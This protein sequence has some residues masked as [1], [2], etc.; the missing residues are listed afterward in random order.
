MAKPVVA[1]LTMCSKKFT[2]QVGFW[3]PGGREPGGELCKKK[4]IIFYGFKSTHSTSFW[5]NYVIFFAEKGFGE[6]GFG[7]LL[8]GAE[9][10]I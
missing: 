7:V 2:F 1:Q 10:L 9:V 6:R 3:V 4:I 8:W 5:V